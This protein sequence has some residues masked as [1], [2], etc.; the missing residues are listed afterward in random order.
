MEHAGLQAFINYLETERG[1][2]GHT[3]KAY[4]LDLDQ[5][6]AYLQAGPSAFDDSTTKKVSLATTKRLA[7]ATRNDIRAFLGHV[8]TAGGTPGTSA[9]KLAS[10][11]AAYKFYVRTDTLKENPAVYIKSPKI[12]RDL[13][14]VLTIPEV[15]EILG[16]PDCSVPL[17]IRDKAILETLYSSG[18]R[19]SELAALSLKDIDRIGGTILVLGKRSK[20]RIAQLGTYALDAISE[21][22][23]IRNDLGTP[24]HTVA[25]VN[26]RGG[27]L[28]TRSVQRVVEKYVRQILPGRREISPHTFRHSFATHM[29]DAGADLRVIQELLGHES[30]STTQIYTHV[31]IDRLKQVYHDT[32]PHAWRFNKT[33]PTIK[34][35]HNPRCGKSR[36]TLNLLR[37]NGIEPEIIDYLNDPPTIQ[38]LEEILRGLNCPASAILRAKEPEYDE[39]ELK[40]DS[41]GESILKAIIQYP[42]LLERP[43]VTNGDKAAIGRPPEN[44]LGVL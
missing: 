30:L 8:Q 41:S 5:F 34:I 36:E 18:V 19:A 31:S 24:D 21:Y 38:D 37:E 22:I 9:R 20:E 1:F 12:P 6:A 39:A 35:Y 42:K 15:T 44:V 11:R 43:I 33:M 10:I 23:R 40:S 25:F 3:V 2:S 7:K 4:I 28:T 13:P 27:P 29:L 26:F 16:A 32:H 17:G 14:D